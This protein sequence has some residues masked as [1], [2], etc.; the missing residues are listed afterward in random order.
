MWSS[1]QTIL[2]FFYTSC[3]RLLPADAQMT[4]S[5]CHVTWLCTWH[6]TQ[7]HWLLHFFKNLLKF[8]DLDVSDLPKWPNGKSVYEICHRFLHFLVDVDY[9]KTYHVKATVRYYT[10]ESEHDLPEKRNVDI[11]IIV[12][13][14]MNVTPRFKG[15]HDLLDMLTMNHLHC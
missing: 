1:R 5:Y 12:S 7:L 13:E 15:T 6:V 9:P 11:N 8:S 14:P 4:P 2:Y 3:V 10:K